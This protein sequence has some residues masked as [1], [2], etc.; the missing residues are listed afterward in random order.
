MTNA[1][2]DSEKNLRS[3][4]QCHTLPSAR[5]H[6][7]PM[8]PSNPSCSK[9][10]LAWSLAWC[11]SVSASVRQ[12]EQEHKRTVELPRVGHWGW[13]AGHPPGHKGH[14]TT[15]WARQRGRL[16]WRPFALKTA[17]WWRTGVQKRYRGAFWTWAF[18]RWL[19]S[20]FVPA[21]SDIIG[22]GDSGMF[23]SLQS[24]SESWGLQFFH[25]RP[26][27]MLVS[28]RTCV[29]RRIPVS[30]QAEPPANWFAV[31]LQQHCLRIAWLSHVPCH[32][33]KASNIFFHFRKNSCCNFCV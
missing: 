7:R 4:L 18:R 10:L 20:R 27:R 11:R 25:L 1:P 5:A 21:I 31:R 15:D 28:M 19:P 13:W 14:N 16:L 8:R 2:P 32:L 24:N 17:R 6:A 3:D 30:G 12:L 23:G 22:S 29:L 26:M 33:G 9:H